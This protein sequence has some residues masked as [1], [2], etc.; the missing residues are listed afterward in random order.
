MISPKQAL[1]IL[2]RRPAKGLGQ[3]FLIHQATA[4]KI[5]ASIHPGPGDVVVEI[6][7]GLGALTL[8]LSKSG[9]SV[10]A[11]EIDAELATFLRKELEKRNGKG[12]K[13]ECMDILELDLIGLHEQF[14]RKMKIIGNLPYNISSP[15]LFKLMEAADYL[16]E[17]VLMLQDE[18]AERVLAGPGNRDYGI[19]SVIVAYH[20]ERRRLMRVKPSQFHPPPKVDSQVISLSFRDCPLTPKVEPSWLVQTVKAAFSHRRKTLRNSLLE[21]KLG[22]LTPDC[23]SKVLQEASIEGSRRAESLTL[24]DFLRLAKGLEGGGRTKLV[25]EEK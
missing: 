14:Q 2:G 23:V 9:A 13:I 10:I 25:D 7:A 22:N 19:L 18:V 16:K 20:S 4:D 11:V 17:A 1:K 15:V 6:G 5:A 24:E 3:H 21:S 8:P 12:V